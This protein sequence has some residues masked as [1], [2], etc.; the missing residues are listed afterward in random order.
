VA[1]DHNITKY[2]IVGGKIFTQ[3]ELIGEHFIL[4]NIYVYLFVS[5]EAGF[6]PSADGLNRFDRAVVYHSGFSDDL[7]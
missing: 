6:F 5:V 3:L 4:F 1:L 2:S 7:T